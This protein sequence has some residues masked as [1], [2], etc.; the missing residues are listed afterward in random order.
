MRV[1]L[2]ELITQAE[3]AEIRRVAPQSISDL[4]RRGR[5]KTVTIGKR[6]FL[7]RS[8]VEKFEPQVGGRPRKKPAKKRG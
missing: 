8:E 7:F 5:L 1:K 4:V 2:D 6:K 3:A